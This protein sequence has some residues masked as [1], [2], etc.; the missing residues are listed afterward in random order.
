MDLELLLLGTA[1]VFVAESFCIALEW[2]LSKIWFGKNNT[3]QTKK[4]VETI[5]D[6][7]KIALSLYYVFHHLPLM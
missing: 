3:G 5:W 4:I 7:R 2:F 6:V 1:K